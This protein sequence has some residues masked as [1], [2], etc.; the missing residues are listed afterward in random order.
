MT[1]QELTDRIEEKTAVLGVIGLGYVGL[2]VA[3][4]FADAGYQVIG[5]DLKADRVDAHED[6]LLLT[7]YK[8]G[9]PISDAARDDTRRVHL[10][11]AIHRGERLQAALYALAAGNSRGTGRYLFL[12]PDAEQKTADYLRRASFFRD[13]YGGYNSKDRL[14]PPERA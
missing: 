4:I 10:L 14:S 8:T 3:A 13:K 7:D 6:G 11:R 12:S 5:V 9:R 2:P 1:F